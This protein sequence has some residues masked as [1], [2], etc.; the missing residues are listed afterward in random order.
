MNRSINSAHTESADLIEEHFK[1]LLDNEP[2]HPAEATQDVLK[3][4][5]WSIVQWSS[6]SPDLNLT[7]EVLWFLK[8]KLKVER[9]AKKQQ[10]AVAALKAWQGIW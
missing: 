2:K 6:Q 7:I 1:V 3:A 5:T 4:T 9:P 10:L 8:T